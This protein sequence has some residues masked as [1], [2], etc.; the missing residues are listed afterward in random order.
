MIDIK[1]DAEKIITKKVSRHG[2]EKKC[3]RIY[4]PKDMIGHD[5]MIILPKKG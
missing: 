3:G 4:V 5:V 2:Y 1:I